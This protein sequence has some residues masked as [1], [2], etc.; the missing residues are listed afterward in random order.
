[1]NGILLVDKPPDIS[2]FGVVSKVRRIASEISGKKIKVGH[3][4]TLDPFATGLLILMIGT[5]TKSAD[6]FLKLDKSYDA[7]MILGKKSSTGDSEG[8]IVETSDFVPAAESINRAIDKHIGRISQVPPAFSAIKV[9]G[10]RAYDLARKGVDVKLE[11]REVNIYSIDRV[12][13]SYPE[14]SFSVRVS[15]GT[16]IRSLAGD[17]GEVLSTGGY[18]SELRRTSVG[19]FNISESHKLEDISVENLADFLI[20]I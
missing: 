3:A 5:A 12:D 7:K 6:K 20:N 18:L 11:P 8:E 10:R 9:G 1:M 4:G 2:S 16:Y 15:S 14:L 17:I 19:E 13:Y